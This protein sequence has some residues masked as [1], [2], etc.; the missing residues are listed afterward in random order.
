MKYAIYALL[1][2]VF[3]VTSV[4][5]DSWEFKK[6][7]I[8]TEFKLGASKL[9]TEIDGTKDQ[10]FPPHSLY[11]YK[12]EQLLA[13]YNNVGFDHVY[14][15]KDNKYFAGVSNFG[16][17]GTAFIV[18]DADGNLLR[19]LKHSYLRKDV[20]TSRSPTITRTWIDEESPDIEFVLQNN[21]LEAVLIRGSNKQKYDLL[22][23]DLSLVP[24]P[25]KP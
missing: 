2:L 12:G 7:L 8:R 24:G 10:F 21:R 1:L 19:E 5:G 4:S 23:E 17:P 25:L 15:S 14:A 3:A 22:K 13:K 9:V 18:F 11:I 6:E 16:I 20:Y